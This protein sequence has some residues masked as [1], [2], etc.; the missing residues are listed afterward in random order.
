MKVIQSQS[1]SLKKSREEEEGE[2]RGESD[3]SSRWHHLQGMK[4]LPKSPLDS[5]PLGGK[6]VESARVF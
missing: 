3:A 4:L 2:N 5:S 6:N 1:Y